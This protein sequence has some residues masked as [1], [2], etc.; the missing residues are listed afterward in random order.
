M[1]SINASCM[2][3]RTIKCVAV[4]IN[5]K[6][7]LIV[8]KKDLQ[9]LRLSNQLHQGDSYSV[10]EQ[11]PFVEGGSS[12]FIF[13]PQILICLYHFVAGSSSNPN[14]H[15]NYSRAIGMPHCVDLVMDT[16]SS[17]SVL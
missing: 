10:V 15:S 8:K 9:Q 2:L 7:H 6:R 5:V 17:V 16:A 13:G 12:Q 14:I 4:T 11:W 1:K 3:L